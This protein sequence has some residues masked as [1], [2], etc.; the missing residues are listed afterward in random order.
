MQVFRLCSAPVQPW[1]IH[2]FEDRPEQV[3]DEETAAPDEGRSPEKDAAEP[4][5]LA[6]V[7]GGCEELVGDSARVGS[8]QDHSF[9]RVQGGGTLR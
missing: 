9:H 6:Q 1:R 7:V 2:V 4:A 5:D 3:G 8:K